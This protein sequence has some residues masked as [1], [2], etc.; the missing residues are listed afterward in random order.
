VAQASRLCCHSEPPQEA[1]NLVFALV[2][3]GFSLRCFSKFLPKPA[4]TSLRLHFCCPPENKILIIAD[5]GK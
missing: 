5:F 2:A 4:G 1:K 3:A